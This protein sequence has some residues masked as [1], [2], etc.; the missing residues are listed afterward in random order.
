MPAVPY[1]KIG[2]ENDRASWL[3]MRATG[4]GASES[5]MLFG[6]SSYG[7]PARVY[8]SKVNPKVE[9]D[10]TPWQ[11][12][13]HLLERLVCKETAREIT[14]SENHPGHYSAVMS[15]DMLRSREWPWMF[16][17]IDAYLRK[18]D[19]AKVPRRVCHMQAKTRRFESWENGPAEDTLIQC[20]HEMAVMGTDHCFASALIGGNDLRWIRLDRDDEFIAQLVEVTG[21]FWERVEN[22]MPPPPLPE[23]GIAQV[24][25]RLYPVTTGETVHLTGEEWTGLDEQWAEADAAMRKAK[26]VKDEISGRIKLALGDAQYAILP[27]GARYNWPTIEKAEV[28]IPAI[29]HRGGLSRRKPQ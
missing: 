1:E 10:A 15:G 26:K 14:E 3:A 23:P 21:K 16:C 8:E 18:E 4:I 2:S 6:Q 22:R 13:G 19:E 5:P 24:V 9:D 12:W 17:T 11:R 27:N 20:Q 25:S 28:T 7:G 29:T